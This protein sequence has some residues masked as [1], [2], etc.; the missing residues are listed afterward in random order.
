VIQGQSYNSLAL[1]ELLAS[2]FFLSLCST[3]SG[4]IVQ[5][6]RNAIARQDSGHAVG[7]ARN[8]ALKGRALVL[9]ELIDFQKRRRQRYED[10]RRNGQTPS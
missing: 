7:K 10:E 8:G 5:F 2:L 1:N 6:E 3:S 4:G 9:Q